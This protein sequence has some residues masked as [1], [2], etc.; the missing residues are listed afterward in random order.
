MTLKQDREQPNKKTSRKAEASL[1][2]LKRIFT[3]PEG[4]H[5]T[6]SHIEAE[7]SANLQGFLRN[8]VVA[9][10]IPPHELQK[11]FLNTDIPED[12]TFVSEHADFLLSKVVAQSVHVSSPSFI[13]HMTSAI[14]Y[15][16]LPLSK[17][18]VALNQNLV[19]IETSK[20]FTPLERQVVGM[21]HRMIYESD[22]SFYREQTHHRE[23]A[24]GVFCSGGT[25]ANI[26]ALWVARNQLL[27]PKDDF[28]GIQEDGLFAAMSTHGYNELAILVSKRAHYSLSKAVDLLG[29][30]KKQLIAIDT[31][32]RDKI[33]L[34]ALKATIQEMK[35]RNCGIVGLVGIAGTTETGT[36]DPLQDMAEIAHEHHIHFHV[37]AAWGGATLLSKKHR[38]LLSGIEQA[39]SVTLDAHKQLYVPMGAGAVLFKDSQAA[40]AI[41]QTA[42]Y[43]IREGSRDIGKYTLE[44]SRPG[45]ALLVH[46]G[47]HIMGRR[48]YELLIDQGIQLAR[49]FASMIESAEDFELISTPELNLLTYR[50]VP[51]P[52]RRKLETASR[53]TIREINHVLDELTESIQKAQRAA[54]QTFVSRTRLESYRYHHEAIVVFR[55]VLANPLTSKQILKDVLSEQRLHA[56]HILGQSLGEKVQSLLG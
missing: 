31:D 24:L 48:G 15:F 38:H 35:K 6:L 27:P 54:G 26:T 14:P 23:R 8:H 47:F 7:I 40:E 44:G 32:H 41:K 17:L 11:D 42:Q 56:A 1:R 29:I 34:T 53:D 13:G 28:R 33:C 9:G 39:N 21:L 36:V 3:V 50:Y 46:A 25:V 52:L 19:K 12:P 37:D 18:V 43:V 55:A 51:A 20:A 30:G 5:S 10:E 16:M 4:N 2:A 49:D 45:S 22:E